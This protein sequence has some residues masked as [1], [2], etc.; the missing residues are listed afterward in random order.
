MTEEITRWTAKRKSAVVLDIIQGE[1]VGLA[2][3]PIYES[4]QC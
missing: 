1:A 3:Q 4:H 2:S